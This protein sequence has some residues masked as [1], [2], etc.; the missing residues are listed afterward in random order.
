MSGF[1]IDMVA[2][3]FKSDYLSDKLLKYS[4]KTIEGK[5]TVAYRIP[6]SLFCSYDT[7]VK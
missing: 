2:S 1:I 5:G 7:K 3:N 6:K 4:I